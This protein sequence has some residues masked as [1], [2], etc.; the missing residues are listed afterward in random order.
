[1]R[2]EYPPTSFRYLKLFFFAMAILCGPSIVLSDP[3]SNLPFQEGQFI[4]NK[5]GQTVIS[6]ISYIGSGARGHNYEVAV[7]GVPGTQV[8]KVMPNATTAEIVKQKR[9]Q[10]DMQKVYDNH[11][12]ENI[13]HQSKVV[14][15]K[16]TKNNTDMVLIFNEKV[17]GSMEN[18]GYAL[19]LNPSKPDLVTRVQAINIIKDQIGLG[20][21]QILDQNLTQRDL[22]SSNIFIN[23]P[24]TGQFSAQD[25]VDGKA[26]AL[27]ADLDSVSSATEEVVFGHMPNLAPEVFNRRIPRSNIS[28]SDFYSL[29]ATTYEM[30]M[31]E[32]PLYQFHKE[33]GL[34]KFFEI[35]GG[36][37]PFNYHILEIMDRYNKAPKQDFATWLRANVDPSNNPYPFKLYEDFLSRG[38]PAE[39]F[40]KW[41]GNIASTISDTSS[42]KNNPNVQ[43]LVHA[44]RN[45]PKG[46]NA[47]IN[48]MKEKLAQKKKEILQELPKDQVKQFKKEWSEIEKFI[49]LGHEQDPRIRFRNIQQH[50]SQF[51]SYDI[52]D[53]ATRPG[54]TR[55]FARDLINMDTGL[56][57]LGCFVKKLGGGL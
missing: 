4:K 54:M 36:S 19:G 27:L 29:A 35:E 22:R 32:N 26:T 10:R 31:G 43:H 49:L 21:G 48:W 37:G 53:E 1:M 5:D 11:G 50:Y 20:V 17:L 33:V 18:Y 12:T 13:H 9:I 23:A 55:S 16:N 2:M 45:H 47:Y 40:S 52:Y 25:I 39:K 56:G 8:M 44:F 14:T 28:S 15:M 30:A 38:Y 41:V 34:G 46:H 3:P 7:R 24:K 57:G 42:W 6:V 51:L